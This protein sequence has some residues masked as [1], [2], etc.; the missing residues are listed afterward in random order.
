MIRA[1]LFDLGDVIVGLDFPRAYRAAARLTGRSV[2]EIPEL[3]GEAGLAN[4]YEHGRIT[5][6]EFH[7]K[8]SAAIG[9]HVSFEEF[10]VL[11]GDM[12]ETGHL[13]PESLLE[14]LH[15]NY[16][17]LIVSNTNELHFDW[18]VE[19]YSVV[20][21]FDD[22]VLSY[23]VGAMKP[24]YGDFSGSNSKSGA[25]PRGVL[26]HRRQG[27]ECQRRGRAGNGRGSVHRRGG[28]GG[29]VAAAGRQLAGVVSRQGW[30]HGSRL[31]SLTPIS[32]L[33]PASH[34]CP[35]LSANVPPERAYTILT[36]S[37]QAATQLDRKQE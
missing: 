8:F 10:R 16:R 11:W 25:P 30:F 5:S 6:R 31:P 28:T 3:I 29:S 33:S 13:L 37:L 23:Q 7:E 9:L 15:Q 27:G 26:L 36:I 19:H 22:C 35:P 24:G 2:E 1:L 20:R 17:M 21:H 14:Q 32:T 34:F 4:A 18:I 12:F